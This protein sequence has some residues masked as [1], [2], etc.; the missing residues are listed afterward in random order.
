LIVVAKE[1]KAQSRSKTPARH[2]SVKAAPRKAK[3][4]T[5]VKAA[6]HKTKV[7]VP[8]R[9]MAQPTKD[10]LRRQLERRDAALAK[11][12]AERKIW[13]KREVELAEQ[14]QELTDEKEEL[15][16]TISETEEDESAAS[17]RLRER[18]DAERK[19][20]LKAEQ[21]LQDLQAPAIH[22]QAMLDAETEERLGRLMEAV[23]RYTEENKA[24]Q[25]ENKKL[26]EQAAAA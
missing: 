21:A 25:A 12:R 16:S 14:I 13:M 4:K 6:P 1:A 2:G 9:Q 19:A 11:L 5:A 8:K 22:R 7:A 20:R 3:A 17:R 18:L 26:K 24:L 15:E 10:E 23:T